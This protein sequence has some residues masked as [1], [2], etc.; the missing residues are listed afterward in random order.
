M[1]TYPLKTAPGELERLF[2]AAQRGKTIVLVD[3]HGRAVKLVPI[4]SLRPTKP[5]KAGSARGRIR[6]ADDFDAPL[7]DFAEYME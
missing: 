7:D 2:D 3:E 4:E 5:R 1:R 6:I